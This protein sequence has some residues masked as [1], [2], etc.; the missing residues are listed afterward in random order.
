MNQILFTNQEKNRGPLEM[1]TVLRIF[2]ILCIV[3]GII[4]AGK[5]AFALANKKEEVKSVPTVEIEKQANQLKLTVKHDKLIDKVIYSWNNEQRETVL[6]GKGRL[7]ME[8]NITLPI[9]TNT[10]KLRVIDIDGHT[11]NYTNEYTLEDGDFTEPEIELLLD[12]AKVKIVAKDETA[13][14]YMEYYWNDEEATTINV[15]ANSPKQIEERVTI[16]KGENTLHIIAV[17]KAGNESEEEQVYK[18]ATKP[19][20]N[21]ARDGKTLII[22][23]TDEDNI[24]RIDYT[25]ND[26]EYSTDPSNTGTP[27]NMKELSIRQELKDGVNKITIKALNTSE[28]ETEVSAEPTV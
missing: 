6:Q 7:Q 23:V 17:D 11:I 12:G 25:L 10:L 27:L 24:K 9:G 28:L 2:A 3:F 13:I 20:I 8:E 5:G 22:T 19:V 14:D 21:V 18:G 26:V 4:L 15:T 16:L 1:S